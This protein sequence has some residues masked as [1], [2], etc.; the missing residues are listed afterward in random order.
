VPGVKVKVEQLTGY[1]Y[2][3]VEEIGL[4]G[5]QPP[6]LVPVFLNEM[7][8]ESI[9]ELPLNDIAYIKYI[10]GIVI[11]AGFNSNV[12]AIYVYTRKGNDQ[13]AVNSNQRSV[14]VKGYDKQKEFVNP[15]Y[16]D[17]EQL[18]YPDL[19]SIVYWN[20][21]ILLDKINNKTT[22]EFYNND[23]SKKLL[24]TIEGINAAGELIHIQK[25]IE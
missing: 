4:L 18:K 17:R 2:F 14:F 5:F 24:L 12:G 7:Q 19:R 13:I 6:T 25:I 15:D 3:V 10:P 22:I 16:T 11:G 23:L 21:S 9:G 8:V 20:P 1:K